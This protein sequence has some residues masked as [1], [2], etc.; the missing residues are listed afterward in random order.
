M[1]ALMALMLLA[2]P[3]PALAQSWPAPDWRDPAVST[4]DRHRWETER[5]RARSDAA[6]ALARQQRLETWLTLLELQAAR[7]PAVA[8]PQD[9]RPLDSP[10]A[11]RTRREGVERRGQTLREGVSGIDSWLDR[12]P[13]SSRERP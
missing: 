11:E 13:P 4:A 8:P 9:W 2:L 5:L 7:Q 6:E 1:R 3:A 12:R 10:E